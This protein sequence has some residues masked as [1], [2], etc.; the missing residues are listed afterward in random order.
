MIAAF[1]NHHCLEEAMSRGYLFC[2]P[3]HD[4][5]FRP[6]VENGAYRKMIAVTYQFG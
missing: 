1:H 6:A 4:A 2:S 5:T 3:I